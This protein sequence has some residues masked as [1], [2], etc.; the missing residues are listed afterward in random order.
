MYLNRASAFHSNSNRYLFPSKNF[1][2]LERYRGFKEQ[3]L[4]I[5]SLALAKWTLPL[6][7]MSRELRD[8]GGC[9]R[10]RERLRSKFSKCIYTFTLAALGPLTLPRIL[11]MT[12]GFAFTDLTVD[13][14]DALPVDD[15]IP[16]YEDN[17]NN[18]SPSLRC[19]YGKHLSSCLR[20]AIA[21]VV[22]LV[23]MDLSLRRACVCVI[24]RL[25]IL[26]NKNSLTSGKKKLKETKLLL[27]GISFLIR[28]H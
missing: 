19:P 7:S 1:Y 6:R 26:G 28:T 16:I 25:S 18:G 27:L 14:I 5:E 4:E 10:H 3:F 15:K 21:T 12:E 23:E 22:F 17:T 13:V 8:R 2:Q 11:Q 9:H 20:K 24:V